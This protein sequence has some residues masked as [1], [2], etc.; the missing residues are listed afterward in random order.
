LEVCFADEAQQQEFVFKD[1]PIVFHDS[2]YSPLPPAGIL[3]RL[4]PCKLLNV[5]IL[6]RAV[7][8]QQIKAHWE[9][10]GVAVREMGPHTLK[11]LPLLTNRWDLILEVPIGTK[12]ISAP[13]LFTIAGFENVMASW[14]FTFFI[15]STYD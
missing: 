13:P 9:K 10:H 14:S 3:P 8:F 5:P 1:E 4:I 7:L 6:S 15:N 2:T 12:S 11:G